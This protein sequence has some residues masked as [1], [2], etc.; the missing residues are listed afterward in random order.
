MP[1]PEIVLR[2]DGVAV[3]RTVVEAPLGG[4]IEKFLAAKLARN[5][6]LA[7][8][9]LGPVPELFASA[10]RILFAGDGSF[11]AGAF[12]LSALNFHAVWKLENGVLRPKF[13]ER[14][15]L[16]NPGSAAEGE[17]ARK[18]LALLP[19]WQETW[20]VYEFQAGEIRGQG[21][22]GWLATLVANPDWKPG[23]KTPRIRTHRLPLP[24]VHSNCSL[25]LGQPDWNAIASAPGLIAQCAAGFAQWVHSPWNDHLLSVELYAH[26]A[27]LFGWTAAGD[28]LPTNHRD[29]WERC[30]VAAPGGAATQFLTKRVEEAC[31][32]DEG[33]AFM[34]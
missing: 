13:L 24:N 14:G 2:E 19:P 5:N 15:A 26:F 18:L 33:F 6:V 31:S 27:A 1:A 23:A 25:C 22:T 4:D 7:T 16:A 12:R 34:P 29:W 3:V 30:P 9:S 20:F 21:A 10:F 28:Q 17:P 11:R 8:P 32:T